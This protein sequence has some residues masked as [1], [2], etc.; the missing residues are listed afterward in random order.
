MPNPASILHVSVTSLSF[1]CIMRAC[2]RSTWTE[3]AVMEVNIVGARHKV[4]L[5][6]AHLDNSFL[7]RHSHYVR[8]VPAEQQNKKSEFAV[9][10]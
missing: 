7:Y 10:M 5:C 2:Y 8:K 3:R 4:R 1:L 6:S 9:C